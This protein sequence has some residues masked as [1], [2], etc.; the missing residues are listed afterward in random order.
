MPGRD[1]IYK[2]A[3]ESNDLRKLGRRIEEPVVGSIKRVVVSIC[4][5]VRGSVR[6]EMKTKFAWRVFP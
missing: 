5:L 3:S 6:A 1:S 4:L 2:L